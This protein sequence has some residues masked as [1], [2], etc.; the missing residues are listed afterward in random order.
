MLK[1][2]VAMEENST[3]TL[4]IT[5]KQLLLMSSIDKFGYNS[6]NLVTLT[7]GLFISSDSMIVLMSV[8][9]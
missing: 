3:I 9:N 7:N 4:K 8:V 6:R 5:F 2:S 1:V